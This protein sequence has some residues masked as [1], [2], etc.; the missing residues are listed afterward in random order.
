[1]ILHH[2]PDI[3]RSVS[4]ERSTDKCGLG[5]V[6]LSKSDTAK[7]KELSNYMRSKWTIT[8]KKR[9]GLARTVVRAHPSD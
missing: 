7:R 3:F 8:T 4:L 6:L 1:M 9:L 5:L 2:F